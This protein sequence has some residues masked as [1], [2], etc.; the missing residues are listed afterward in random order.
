MS[1]DSGEEG[2]AR[3]L[4]ASAERRNWTRN[5]RRVRD[6]MVEAAS[7]IKLAV[8]IVSALSALFLAAIGAGSVGYAAYQD[9]KAQIARDSTPPAMVKQK[10]TK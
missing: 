9:F 5:G 3:P 4:E 1:E 10:E 6:M 8:G 7:V 2:K